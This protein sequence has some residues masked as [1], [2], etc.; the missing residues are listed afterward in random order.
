ME[1]HANLSNPASYFVTA[2]EITNELQEL[3]IAI[4]RFLACIIG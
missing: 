4:S 2:E 1:L 3:W